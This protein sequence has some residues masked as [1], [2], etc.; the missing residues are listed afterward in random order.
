MGHQENLPL[1]KHLGRRL[2][3]NSSYSPCE[4]A[5]LLAIYIQD[6]S[7]IV[8]ASV[9]STNEVSVGWMN[10]IETYLRTE[11]LLEESK[12]THNIRVQAARFT[13]I[14]D[15]LYKK[16]FRGSYIRCL[17]NMKTQYV[18]TKLHEGV[19][20]NHAGG[21]TLAH[22]AHSQ[23]YYWPTM[24]QG[25][26]NYVKRCDQCQRHAPIPH[27]PFDDLNPVTSP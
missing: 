7:S 10:K 11:S 12:Q 27:M 1:R 4:K 24:K 21:Q 9:C 8:V 16:S 13:L 6:T 26:A 20:G 23:G 5:M 14:G 2:S 17:N 22:H 3:W 25:A 15:I 18:L 19:C